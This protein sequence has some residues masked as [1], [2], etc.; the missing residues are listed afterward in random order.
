MI[1]QWLTRLWQAALGGAASLYGFLCGVCCTSERPLH[2][3]KVD[4]DMSDGAR[5]AAR[6]LQTYKEDFCFAASQTVH[7]QQTSRT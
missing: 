6:P 2:F 4:L 5:P 1:N 3:V 7:V